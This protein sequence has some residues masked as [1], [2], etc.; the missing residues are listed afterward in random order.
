MIGFMTFRNG[1]Q[2]YEFFILN[3]YIFKIKKHESLRIIFADVREW[4]NYGYLL[5]LIPAMVAVGGN[6]TGGWWS[7]S[8]IV[9]S[10]GV[11]SVVELL[12]GSNTS[13]RHSPSADPFPV[14]ILYL[15][16]VTHS[17]VIASLFYGI[18]SGILTGGF[19]LAAAVSSGVAAG[20]GAVVVGHELVH[21]A[22]RFR[23]FAGDYLL[24]LS[25]NFYFKIHHLRIHHR[26][27]GFHSDAATAR[28]GESLYRFYLR[29]IAGQISQGWASE[30]NRLAK[31]GKSA[32]SLHNELLRN[33]LLQMVLI[34]GAWLILGF[35]AAVAWITIMVTAAFLLE[36]VNYIEHYGLERR[37]GEKM[38][39]IHSW[40]C[41][42]VISRFLLVDLSRHADHHF[43]ASR[44]YHT[45]ESHQKSP[46][47]PGGY[48]SMILPALLPPLWFAIVHPRLDSLKNRK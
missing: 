36:Y 39:V 40:N 1:L 24:A 46:L 11:L 31:Q 5:S 13:N 2:K 30:K 41:D 9:F 17:I 18:Y 15:H 14:L 38:D 25:G 32:M 4:R 28:R 21:K 33:I 37:K 48:A 26:D 22:Q 44:P 23:Q 45:L 35:I 7:V 34:A 42:R 16:L 19:V 12:A 43:H 10:L 6:L 20:S 3:Q 47:L 29:T 27:A 8:N